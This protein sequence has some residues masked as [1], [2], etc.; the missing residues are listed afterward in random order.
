MKRAGEA[1]YAFA[2]HELGELFESGCEFA[3][4]PRSLPHALR[5][6]K[7]AASNGLDQSQ[8]N[9]AKMMLVG[10]QVD[11]GN[12]ATIDPSAVPAWNELLFKARY[13][14]QLAASRGNAEARQLVE[15]TFPAAM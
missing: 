14:L 6:Y 1:E 4:V 13:W 5:W 10:S 11:V 7:R 9:L 2:Q 8:L 15:R 12:V 3:Q